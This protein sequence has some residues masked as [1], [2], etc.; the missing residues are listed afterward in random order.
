MQI[1]AELIHNLAVTLRSIAYFPVFV[2]GQGFCLCAIGFSNPQIKY[3][4]FIRCEIQFAVVEH[5]A[6]V[7]PFFAAEQALRFFFGFQVKTPDAGHGTATVF[8]HIVIG[9]LQTKAGE[10]QVTA[11]VIQYR[12]IRIRDREY[13]ALHGLRIDCRD[14][15]VRIRAGAVQ[16]ADQHFAFRCPA[17][18]I[19]HFVFKGNALR[20]ATLCRHH[21]G[22][23]AAFIGGDEGHPLFIKRNC[24]LRFRC[25]MRGQ[26]LRLTA[27]QT[28]FPQITFCSEHKL[29]AA[30]GWKAQIR[31]CRPRA[32]QNAPQRE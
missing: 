10:I 4:V 11:A 7:V 6:A 3:A 25:R 8:T 12:V 17:Q 13:T 32:A 26:T 15:A 23:A 16:G 14:N 22:F 19:H 28:G 30:Y 20:Y 18:Y 5:R 29:V 2:A 21:I 9:H 24:R 1:S 27:L 31:R